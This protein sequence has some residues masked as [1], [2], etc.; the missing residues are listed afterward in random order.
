MTQLR[1]SDAIL[2]GDSLKARDE[3]LFLNS[4]GTCGCAIGGAILAAGGSGRWR[5]HEVPQLK[6]RWP[7]LT[8]AIDRIGTMYTR[9]E[10]IESIAAYADSI[11]PTPRCEPTASARRS[12]PRKGRFLMPGAT[13]K[14]EM[15]V[16]GW[17]IV[18]RDSEGNR[19]CIETGIKSMTQAQKRIAYWTKQEAKANKKAESTVSHD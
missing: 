9:R 2:L 7:W 4:D 11:D 10:S 1:L 17:A 5:I 18:M 3:R 15:A 13:Y 8:P 19:V 6:S 14:A 12:S 16:M